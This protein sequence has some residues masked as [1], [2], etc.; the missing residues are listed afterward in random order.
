MV[1]WKP[2][3]PKSLE[4]PA[5]ASAATPVAPVKPQVTQPAPPKPHKTGLDL[6]EMGEADSRNS[7]GFDPY[8]SGAF[9][10]KDTWSKVN[11]KK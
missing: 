3:R 9:N 2:S 10:I 5:V 4:P 11:R 7:K 6:D 1:L 8:N